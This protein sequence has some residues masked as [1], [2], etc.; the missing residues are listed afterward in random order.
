M[1]CVHNILCNK[2]KVINILIKDQV[3]IMVN[4]K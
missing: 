3:E 1:H 2:I 4:E